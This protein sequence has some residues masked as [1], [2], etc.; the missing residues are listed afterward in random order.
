MKP[1]WQLPLIRLIFDN[2]KIT[3]SL[4]QLGIHKTCILCCDYY[5]VMKK[6]GKTA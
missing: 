4:I 1:P 2:G 6:S 3:D 5:H